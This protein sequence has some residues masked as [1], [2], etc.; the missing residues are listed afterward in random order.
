[1]NYNSKSKDSVCI[2]YK[3]GYLVNK[4][5]MINIVKKYKK[6]YNNLLLI[7]EDTRHA[8]FEEIYELVK[9]IVIECNQTLTNNILLDI[10]SIIVKTKLTYKKY[11]ALFKV[12]N[13][14]L[15]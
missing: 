2:T 10:I 15:S 8:L 13:I 14:I 12:F 7:N 6:Y 1:M 3:G 11:A 4:Y 5:K 9:E